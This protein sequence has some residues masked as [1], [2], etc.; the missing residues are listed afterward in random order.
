MRELEPYDHL[1]VWRLDRLERSPFGMVHAL[2]WLVNRGV[3][4]RI[5]EHGGMQ[6]DLDKPMGK[7]LVMILAGFAG[8]FA[9]QLG[10]AIRAGI[11]LRKEHGLA[12]HSHPLPYVRDV[13]D[14]FLIRV[15]TR[16][17]AGHDERVRLVKSFRRSS[18]SVSRANRH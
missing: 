11:A 8:F 12:Y 1:L 15:I 7:L 18:I 4:V 17:L 10:E 2:Q 16:L 9:D 14:R 13:C 3:N 6:I 5:L